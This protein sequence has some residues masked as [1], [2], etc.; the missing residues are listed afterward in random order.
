MLGYP[1]F[2]VTA[3]AWPDVKENFEALLE[4]HIIDELF[5]IKDED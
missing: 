4:S 2:D 5:N 1:Y 3:Y